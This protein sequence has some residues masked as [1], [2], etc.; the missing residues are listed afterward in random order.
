MLTAL[1][2]GELAALLSCGKADVHKLRHAQ[3]VLRAGGRYACWRAGWLDGGTTR[4]AATLRPGTNGATA[5]RPG[6]TWQVT[7][8]QACVKLWCLYPSVDD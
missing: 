6:S 4:F 8:G 3:V 1:E 5:R 7:T 2:R